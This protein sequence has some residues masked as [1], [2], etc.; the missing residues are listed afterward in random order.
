MTPDEIFVWLALAFPF[1]GTALVPIVAKLGASAR[2]Y[3]SVII[4]FLTAGVV[5][6]LLPMVWMGNSTALQYTFAW[7]PTIG[8]SFSVYIDPLS[9][10]MAVIAGVIG[11][12]VLLYSVKY[13]HG[14]DG[15]TRYYALVLLF[16]GSMIGL[17]FVDNL[18][19]LYFFWEAVGLCS[20]AL[21]GFYTTD[22]KA[23]KA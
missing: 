23:A 16:I 8:L 19:V 15:L 20:Y 4:G 10:M 11:S 14:Q 17:V 7:A 12:L 21:I 1:I 3:F 5:L 13:M 2:A 6:L 9:I 22:P 18:L